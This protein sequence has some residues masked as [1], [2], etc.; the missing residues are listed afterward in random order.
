[1]TEPKPGSS[2]K[3]P[4]W[5]AEVPYKPTDLDKLMDVIN[6]LSKIVALGY[7]LM[8]AWQVAKMLNPPLQVKQDMFIAALKQK[9]AKPTG[10]LPELSNSDRAELYDFLRG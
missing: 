6:V 7:T 1:M 2:P 9:L 10:G 4:V 8:A 5:T 3:T